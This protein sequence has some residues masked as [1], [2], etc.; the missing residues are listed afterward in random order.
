MKGL[1]LKRSY[2]NNDNNVL[3]VNNNNPKTTETIV[4]DTNPL[5]VIAVMLLSK[6]AFRQLYKS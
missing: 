1:A 4:R 2:S 6:P 3:Y 5:L